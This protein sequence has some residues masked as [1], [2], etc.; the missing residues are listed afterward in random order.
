MKNAACSQLVHTMG[1]GKFKNFVGWKFIEIMKICYQ[2]I[3][4][5]MVK[6]EILWKLGIGTRN[7]GSKI[8]QD[9][10]RRV[11]DTYKDLFF[12]N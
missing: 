2:S 4:K 9:I 10:S 6:M 5:Y 11:S 12:S 8:F 1:A 7:L 3:E